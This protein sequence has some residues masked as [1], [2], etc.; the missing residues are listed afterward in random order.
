VT[1]SRFSEDRL[2]EKPTLELLEQ[3][4]YETADGYTER[5][6]AEYIAH[7]GLGRDD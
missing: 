2:V 4:G 6:G 5:F 7:G 1:P 3:L